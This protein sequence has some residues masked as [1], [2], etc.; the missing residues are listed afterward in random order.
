M[1]ITG[2][3]TVA[4]PGTIEALVAAQ[5]MVNCPV[6]VKALHSNTDLVYVCDPGVDSD[7]GLHLAADEVI[8]YDFV[9][10]LANIWIDA[11]VAGEGVR[12]ALLSI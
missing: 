6:M 2:E 3:Q 9:G 5:Q 11:L 10:N 1:A 12:W 7:N 8:I 4:V